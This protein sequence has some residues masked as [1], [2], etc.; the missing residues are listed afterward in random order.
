MMI[1]VEDRVRVPEER[2]PQQ[3]HGP[4]AQ[5][6]PASPLRTRH[7]RRRLEFPERHRDLGPLG[8]AQ[9]ERDVRVRVE[10]GA[11]DQRGAGAGGHRGVEE[12][13]EPFED[14][15]GE[16]G[17]GFPAV[18]DD[19]EVAAESLDGWCLGIADFDGRQVDVEE[20]ALVAN[21]ETWS[22]G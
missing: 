11:R 18:D 2:I 19:G 6:Q 22:D 14:A 4:V 10:E 16:S 1:Q 21:F 3:G 8:A 20:R 9:A 5:A 7:V 17:V 12:V 15:D 13:C